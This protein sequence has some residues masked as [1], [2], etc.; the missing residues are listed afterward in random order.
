M[1]VTA[2]GEF[3]A[4]PIFEPVA[5]A[6]IV[7]EPNRHGRPKKARYPGCKGLIQGAVMPY[8]DAEWESESAGARQGI[9]CPGRYPR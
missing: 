5:G 4:P 3:K 7:L 1:P 8:P 9:T 2:P 6:L